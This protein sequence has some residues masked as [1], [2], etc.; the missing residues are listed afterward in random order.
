MIYANSSTDR[1]V[2]SDAEVMEDTQAGVLNAVNA[3]QDRSGSFN[4][5]SGGTPFMSNAKSITETIKPNKE[6]SN[7]SK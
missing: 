2:G 6:D 1:D 7:G 5:S 4:A 3:G